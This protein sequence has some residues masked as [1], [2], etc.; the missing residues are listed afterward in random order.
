MPQ[1]TRCLSSSVRT[2]KTFKI[3]MI[4][5]GLEM[6]LQVMGNPAN[7]EGATIAVSTETGPASMWTIEDV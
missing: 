6:N 5:N 1:L 3:E 7:K 4:V 2:Y